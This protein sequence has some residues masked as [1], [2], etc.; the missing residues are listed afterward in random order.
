MVY[1]PVVF[2]PVPAVHQFFIFF[3]YMYTV[4]YIVQWTTSW[5]GG[6]EKGKLKKGKKNK[7]K[8]EKSSKWAGAYSVMPSPPPLPIN[9]TIFISYQHGIFAIKSSQVKVDL[10]LDSMSRIS[11]WIT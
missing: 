1:I 6:V 9:V 3:V 7:E 2:V 11:S 5:G 8:M 10:G 4:L